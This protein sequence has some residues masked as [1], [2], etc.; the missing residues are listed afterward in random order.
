[1]HGLFH[2][3]G[4]SPAQIETVDPARADRNWEPGFKTKIAPSREEAIRM[5]D[6]DSAE[7]QVYT[8]GSGK[9]GKIGAAAVLFHNGRRIRSLRYLLGSDAD[10]TVPEGEGVAMVLGLELLRPERTVRRVSFAADNVSAV[11]R[12]TTA[13]AAPMQYIWDLFR[14]RWDMVR[15]QFRH[16][17]LTIRWVPGHEGVA[18]NEEADRLAKKAVEEGSSAARR[19]PAPLRKPIPR[20]KQAA[21]RAVNDT[22]KVRARRVWRVSPRRP[23]MDDID[24]TMP[25]AKFLQLTEGLSRHKAS[26]LIQLRSGHAPLQAHLFRMRKAD[27]ATCPGCG[28]ERE[29]VQHYLMICP[30][31]RDQRRRLIAAGGGG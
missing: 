26:L 23:R 13:R 9:D 11:Q 12:S 27:S 29:T 7:W 4:I 5:D 30:A 17:S 25:S 6:E 21:A 24:K 31:Y 20:S 16:I 1:M 3:F 28:R 14:Q 2:D 8:D 10:H 15:R 22:L 19:L 18:G